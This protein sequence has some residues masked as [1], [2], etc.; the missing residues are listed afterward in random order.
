MKVEKNNLFYF[1]QGASLLILM[2]FRVSMILGLMCF[3]HLLL[4]SLILCN[5][6]I[7][8]QSPVF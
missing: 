4:T 6:Q 2:F 8:Q 1:L 3:D 5:S 7:L